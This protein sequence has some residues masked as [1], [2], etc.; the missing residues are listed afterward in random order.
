[1]IQKELSCWSSGS[2]GASWQ[3]CCWGCCWKYHC[4]LWW[5]YIRP[6]A[7]NHQSVRFAEKKF[8]IKGIFQRVLMIPWSLDFMRIPM[9]HTLLVTLKSGHPVNTLPTCC[10]SWCWTEEISQFCCILL[11]M[12]KWR[13]IQEML[14]GLEKCP[15]IEMKSK[16]QFDIKS[17]SII[18]SCFN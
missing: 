12:M 15:G 10:R 3:G 18:G 13:I 6:S 5:C 7:S 1:L 8:L 9:V 2:K 11:V 16:T 4:C 14:C 17:I